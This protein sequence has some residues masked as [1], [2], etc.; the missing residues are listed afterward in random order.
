M[1]IPS[2]ATTRPTPSDFSQGGPLDL[3]RHP[4]FREAAERNATLILAN[5]DRYGPV[6]KWLM[7]DVGRAATL[8]RVHQ[9]NGLGGGVSVGD[10]LA[11]TR[12]RNTASEGRVIQILQRAEAAG[13]LT[14]AAGDGAWST[15][16]ITIGPL[17]FDIF[18]E[19]AVAEIDAA[20]LVVPEIRPGLERL[21]DD[22]FLM[23]FMAA[24]D[25]FDGA[26][27]P[28]LGPPNPAFRQLLR[29][30]GGLVMLYDLFLLQPPM[31]PRLI[32]EAPFSRA[33][34]AARF[35]LSR[36]H[37]RRV[38]EE[39]ALAGYV[40]FPARNRIVCSPSLSEE[41]ERHFARTFHAIASAA[42][43]ALAS[44]LSAGIG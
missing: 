8:S 36:A 13:L 40:S 14:I 12:L 38:F 30:E 9:L 7:N 26:H 15:R 11:R 19:R 21:G 43:A 5:R 34:L 27:R 29:R 33:R 1:P 42:S 22:R 32:T 10:V 4:R 44:D 3:V 23:A 6:L 25:R 24:L 41:A 2:V 17:M 18:R 31:R 39:A 20:S 16:G 28:R 35:N 37:V